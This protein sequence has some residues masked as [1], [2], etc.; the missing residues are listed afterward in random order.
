M[1]FGTVIS[2][3][4]LYFRFVAEGETEGSMREEIWKFEII[5]I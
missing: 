3:S 2:I 5:K 1:Q 4:N